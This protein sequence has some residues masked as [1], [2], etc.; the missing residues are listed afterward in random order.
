[1]GEVKTSVLLITHDLAVASQ[2]ADR[3]VVMYAGDLVE[4]SEV[5]DLFSDPLHPYTKGLLSCIPSGPKDRTRLN[6]IPGTVP[7]LTSLNPNCKYASR[8][9]HAMEMCRSKKPPLI[10]AKPNHKVACFLYSE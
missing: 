7:E 10:E 5:H 6:P 8:C 3:V 9:P 1:M 2:V 4:D